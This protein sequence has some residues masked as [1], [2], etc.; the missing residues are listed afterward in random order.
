MRTIKVLVS[1]L[2]L[3][4]VLFASVL[5][6]NAIGFDAEEVY[7]SVFVVY[8][9]N[10]LGSGFA[11]GENCIVT[12]AHVI[13]NVHSITL[14]SYEGNKY[15]ASLL[16]IDED[17]DIAVLII[18]DA[19]FPY[20]K[21]AN[22]STVKIGDDI[23][24]IGAP[25]GMAYTLT[26]GTVSAK[27]RI[28]ENESFI[29]IDAAINE[30]NSG[31]PLLNDAG[32]VLGMNTMKMT[33]SEGI[34]LAIPADRIASTLKELGVEMDTN[35]NVNSTMNTPNTTTPIEV[36]SDTDKSKDTEQQ[37]KNSL[38][39]VTY[40]AIVIAAV[41]LLGNIILVILL[42][43]QKRKNLSIKYNPKERTDFDIDILE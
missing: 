14:T 41:S 30:G 7:K 12:N 26:K 20:L 18:K 23:Y 36:P 22:L 35:G 5:P 2:I 21:M 8:S 43:Y 40:A 31:G 24:A 27:E 34:G 29:Q 9:G 1:L 17:K 15:T 33:D 6:A 16:G 28:V 38:P 13:E 42:I 3:A 4:A 10:S 19:S 25:K 37:E 11:I 39:T 32:E